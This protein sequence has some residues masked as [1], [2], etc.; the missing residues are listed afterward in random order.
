MDPLLVLFS[1]CFSENVNITCKI[2]SFLCSLD[3]FL[4]KMQ[5]FSFLEIKFQNSAHLKKRVIFDLLF[6]FF[7]HQG[8]DT[9]I[10]LANIPLT[11]MHTHI[12]LTLL[13]FFW[14]PNFAKKL[15]IYHV[16]FLFGVSPGADSYLCHFGAINK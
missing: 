1:P 14:I 3:N 15:Q 13:T 8:K 7:S 6:T 5:L 4:L 10:P 12:L 16:W 2:V 9:K 11:Y